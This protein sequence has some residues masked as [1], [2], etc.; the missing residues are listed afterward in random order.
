M[1]TPDLEAQKENYQ[2]LLLQEEIQLNE[3]YYNA[4]ELFTTAPMKQI[5]KLNSVLRQISKLPTTNI[6]LSPGFCC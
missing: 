5:Y 3:E 1:L 2:N 4:K 6:L